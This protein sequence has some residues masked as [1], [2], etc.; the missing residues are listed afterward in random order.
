[1]SRVCAALSGGVDSAAAAALLLRQ[2]HAVTG[3]MMI[4]LMPHWS[5]RR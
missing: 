1:M 2:G 4:M 3:A 5:N